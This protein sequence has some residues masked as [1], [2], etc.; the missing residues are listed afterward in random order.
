MKTISE[1]NTVSQLNSRINF[2]TKLINTKTNARTTTRQRWIE[3][4]NYLS[5]EENKDIVKARENKWRREKEI[6]LIDPIIFNH[7]NK[8]VANIPVI[9]SVRESVECINE[10]LSKLDPDFREVVMKGS[11]VGNLFDNVFPKKLKNLTHWDWYHGKDNEGV[12]CMCE[13][14][15]HYF[16]TELKTTCCESGKNRIQRIEGSK[17]QA[18]EPGRG[19][20][21]SEDKYKFYI[22]VGLHKE[23]E[24][25]SINRIYVGMLKPSDWHASKDNDHSGNA[26]VLINVFNRQFLK[27][28]DYQW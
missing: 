4:L 20:K 9:K 21:Y 13:I 22:F 18:C 2:L 16:D 14:E 12:D 28:Y 15:D 26:T 25:L 7:I 17:T 19:K 3:E 6:E 27:I 24:G 11:T 8:Y 23:I 10:Q 5:T 1:Y